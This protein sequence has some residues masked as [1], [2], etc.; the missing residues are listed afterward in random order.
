[1]KQYILLLAL[2]IN[3]DFSSAEETQ[4]TLQPRI[5]GGRNATRNEFPFVVSL[6]YHGDPQ[7]TGTI[8]SRY[9]VLTAAHC[10]N[11]TTYYE[12]TVNAGFYIKG[13]PNT[14]ERKVKCLKLHYNYVVKGNTAFDI[15]IMDVTQPFEFN[16]AV[17]PVNFPDFHQKLPVGTQATVV[18]WGSTQ[19][20]PTLI[21]PLVLQTL[22]VVT[23]SKK[24]CKQRWTNLDRTICAVEYTTKK[25]SCYG[26]SG[27]PLMIRYVQWG[28]ISRGTTNCIADKPLKFLK[29]SMFTKWIKHFSKIPCQKN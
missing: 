6:L 18:G 24:Q 4:N 17:Q 12:W 1:M 15:A 8:F 29:I 5:I 14:I 21:L 3:P 2:C 27:G 16:A 23:I 22:K 13:D 9:H 19:F 28:L 26:D 25:S 11:G 20:Q 10:I 7:C